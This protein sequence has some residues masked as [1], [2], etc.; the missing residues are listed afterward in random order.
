MRVDGFGYAGYRT[1]TRFDPL[2]AKL[3]VRGRRPGR[4]R[5]PGPP[6]AGEFKIGGVRTNIAFLQALLKS[7]ALA[8]GE[9]HTRYVEEHAAEL[10]AAAG[11]RARYFGRL[12]RRSAGRAPGSTRWIPWRCWTCSPVPGRA[13]TRRPRRPAG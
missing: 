2:L 11:E 4:R 3:I 13:Q 7:P 8:A 6:G 9:L 5:G 1:S 10:L 12:A